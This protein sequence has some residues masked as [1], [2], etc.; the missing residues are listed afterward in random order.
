[1]GPGGDGV[2]PQAEMGSEVAR[3]AVRTVSVMD[4][5]LRSSPQRAAALFNAAT[6]SADFIRE[7]IE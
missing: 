2:V 1:M 5:R 4:Q 7:S 3:R 6:A